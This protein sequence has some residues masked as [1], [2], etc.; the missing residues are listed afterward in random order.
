MHFY[1]YAVSLNVFKLALGFSTRMS[2]FIL[3]SNDRDAMLSTPSSWH[4]T[5]KAQVTRFSALH[6]FNCSL[7]PLLFYQCL[8]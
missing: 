7:T 2:F 6:W 4:R 8:K 1:K 5:K 3:T